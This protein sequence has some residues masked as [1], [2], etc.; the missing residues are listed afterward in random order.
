MH[1]ALRLGV[2]VARRA[3]AHQAGVAIVFAGAY[4]LLNGDHLL[5]SGLAD[6]VVGGESDGRLVELAQAV[7]DGRPLGDDPSPRPGRGPAHRP[8]RRIGL[9]PLDRYARLVVGDE[10]RLAGAVEA[11]RGCKHLCRHCPLPPVHGGRFRAIAADVVAADIDAL[12]RA[13]ARHIT[14]ADPDFLN[15]PTHARRVAGALHAAHPDLTWD[16]TAKV[17]HLVDH[18]DL[19]PGFAAAGCLFVVSAVESLSPVVLERLAKGHA[20]ADVERALSA[21]R[22][23]GIALRP[24]WVAFTPWTTLADAAEMLDFV[25][26]HDLVD[27]VD[28][29]QYTVRLL[30]PP[31]SLLADDPAFG[32]L[33]V[34]EF[35]HRWSHPDRRM[36]R[37][38]ETFTA[39]VEEALAAGESNARIHGRL[40]AAVVAA[41]GPPVATAHP[42]ERPVPRMSEDW[43]C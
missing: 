5:S 8:P 10:T 28:P 26:E 43:F 41:G 22:T 21:C 17:S 34:E 25:A 11:S 9:A 3:R 15:G 14:F 35:A 12:A 24:T 39:L 38:H 6:R 40:A 16:F 32:P 1:T 31:G 27:A 23:A 7:R 29:V 4:A 30:V 2:A 18:G 33:V 13:G 20:R 19:L 36:D 42:A 37:L